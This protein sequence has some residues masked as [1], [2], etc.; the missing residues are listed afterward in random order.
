MIC[1]MPPMVDTLPDDPETL[2]AMLVAERVRT[3]RLVQ[4]IKELQRHRFGRQAEALPEDQCC[5]RSKTS[6]RPKRARRR[7][8][9]RHLRPSARL[10][11]RQAADEPR[12]FAGASAADRDDRRCRGQGLPVL[13][14]RAASDRRGCQREARRHPSAVPS[15]GRASA[16][17]CVP[18]L[19]GRRRPVARA[20]AADRGRHADGSDRRPCHRLQIR[21]PLAAVSPG[22]DLRPARHS[23]RSLD[24][25]RLGRPRRVPLAPRPRP[26][27]RYLR[28]STKL[29]AD[30][31]RAPVLDPG[32]GP[33]ENWSIMGLRARRS[34]LAWI[35]PAGVAYVYAP[36]QEGRTAHR[37][38][39]RLQR[40]SPGRWLRRLSRAGRARRRRTRFLLD[41]CAPPVL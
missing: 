24:S 6:S 22:P 37:T 23:S 39:R 10:R 16:Q 19:R 13:Q 9:S 33:N 4:I 11:Q 31:T 26:A 21:R 2:K 29:F 18:G 38:S 25:R 35:G 1:R 12:L 30:E 40:R 41:A 32:R 5:S 20:G 36:D 3:E 15:A 8:L 7:R 28:S 14:G 17:I 27:F 34:A